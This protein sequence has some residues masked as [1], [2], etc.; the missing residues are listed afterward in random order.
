MSDIELRQRI[1]SGDKAVFRAFYA[2]TKPILVGYIQ[3]RIPSTADAEEIMQDSYLSFLDS[4]PLFQGNSSLETF[5]ISIAK[6]EIADYWRKYYAK[7][8]IHTL[9]FME[10][11]YKESIYSA[12]VLAHE[13]E[14]TYRELHHREAQ[15]LRLKYED[16]LSIKQIAQKLEISFKAAESRLFRARQ[17]FQLAYETVRE[18]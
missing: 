16:G 4:L 7:K 13:I 15:I 14:A 17:S 12:A 11:I 18:E 6:H 8:A 5:L 9:P 1:L 10:Q 2:Q 3:Q